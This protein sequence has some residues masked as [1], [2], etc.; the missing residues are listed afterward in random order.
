V[1]IRA[2]P[3]EAQILLDGGKVENPFDANFPRSDVRHS[4]LVKAPGYR[5]ETQW[6]SFGADS[7]LDIALQ[8]GSGSH[9][10][11]VALPA[12]PPVAGEP[13]PAPETK[14]EV[15]VAKPESKPEPKPAAKAETK[16]D[17]KPE[18]KPVYKGTKGKLITEFPE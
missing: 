8:K 11:K 12:P 7:N 9:E 18:A 14:P 13:K 4:L 2:L 6:I 5:A 15:K 17:A 1:H 16:P 3:A 10:R